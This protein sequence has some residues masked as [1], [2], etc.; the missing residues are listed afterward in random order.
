MFTFVF[1]VFSVKY[2][3]LIRVQNVHEKS[4]KVVVYRLTLLDLQ[5]SWI[6][7]TLLMALVHMQGAYCIYDIYTYTH[8]YTFQCHLL[9]IFSNMSAIFDNVLFILYGFYSFLILLN[10][11]KMLMLKSL[12][13]IAYYTTFLEYRL[14]VYCH[15]NTSSMAYF[16]SFW[17]SEQSPLNREFLSQ[18]SM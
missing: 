10:I 7:C 15:S 18:K 5:T 17:K 1:L 6:E 11:L 3:K 16:P 4:Y 2:Y 12:F 9:S 14:I 8:I 13:H